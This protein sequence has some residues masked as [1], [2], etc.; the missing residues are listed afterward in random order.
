[1]VCCPAGTSLVWEQI[2]HLCLHQR[3]HL[4]SL[5]PKKCRCRVMSQGKRKKRCLAFSEEQAAYVCSAAA[6]VEL[7]YGPRGTCW[8]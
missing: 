1:M 4:Y 5:P 3:L 7:L 8:G 2:A 6:A